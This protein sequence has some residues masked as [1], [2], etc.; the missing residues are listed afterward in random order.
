ME[1]VLFALFAWLLG[2]PDEGSTSLPILDPWEGEPRARPPARAPARAPVPTTSA[3]LASVIRWI[4]T[5]GDVVEATGLGSGSE[6]DALEAAR[7]W[8]R[9]A[10]ADL[11]VSSAELERALPRLRVQ[12]Y[13]RP[14]AADAPIGEVRTELG[15]FEAALPIADDRLRGRVRAALGRIEGLDFQPLA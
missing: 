12:H 4:F 6:A 5:Q 7:T 9:A 13:A 10:F 11:A 1:L 2:P 15:R 8:V 3:G 14:L